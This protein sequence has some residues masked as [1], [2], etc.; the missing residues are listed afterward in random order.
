MLAVF[1]LAADLRY[2]V[3]ERGAAVKPSVYYQQK[4][5]GERR[6]SSIVQS[7]ALLSTEN[8]V[9]AKIQEEEFYRMTEGSSTRIHTPP[10]ITATKS[11]TKTL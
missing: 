2:Y 6:K 8:V 1:R 10:L 3:V 4:W 11:G 7:P 9:W 5:N